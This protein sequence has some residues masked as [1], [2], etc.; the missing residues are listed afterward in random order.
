MP[1]ETDRARETLAPFAVGL[2]MDVGFGGSALVK[3]CLTHDMPQPYTSTGGD[4]QILRGDARSFPFFCD[5]ALDWISQ[6]HLLED[7][8]YAELVD[9][10]TEWRRILKVGGFLI[11]NCPDQMV[12]KDY[13]ARHSQGDN[14]AHVEK[15][16]S[17]STF[18]E[19]VLSNTGPWEIVYENPLRDGYSWHLVCK[20]L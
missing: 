18:K 20:K 14:L 1:S 12:F 5:E 15:D 8:S 16:M 7:F 2:G 11:M 10:I 17:L 9:I 4:K 6:S 19:H 3:G 13:I